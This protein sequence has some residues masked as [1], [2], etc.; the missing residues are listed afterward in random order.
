ME[1]Q[2]ISQGSLAKLKSV[3]NYFPKGQIV[4]QLYPVEVSLTWAGTLRKGIQSMNCAADV[5]IVGAAKLRFP[6]IADDV[7][8]Q[9]MFPGGTPWTTSPRLS[10]ATKC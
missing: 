8:L 10:N 5:R 7:G 4:H 1:D 9:D 3:Y 6:G 2:P